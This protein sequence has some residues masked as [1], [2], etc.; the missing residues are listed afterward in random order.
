MPHFGQAIISA[1]RVRLVR[2]A[3]FFSRRAIAVRFG[4]LGGE[5]RAQ[6]ID[7][8][9]MIIHVSLDFGVVD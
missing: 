5:Q 3:I 8:S 1:A 2:C 9:L 4:R 7:P 6:Q